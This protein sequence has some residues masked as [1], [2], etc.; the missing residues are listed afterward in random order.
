MIKN[1]L[2]QMRLIAMTLLTG[3]S[4]LA[5]V[6]AASAGAFA[7]N[8]QSTVGTGMAYAG[9]AAGGTLSDQF[10]N[11][12]TLGDVHGFQTE[13]DLTAILPYVNVNTNPTLLGGVLPVAGQRDGNVGI[14]ALVPASNYA[15]R[16]NQNIILGLGINSPFDL[17]TSYPGSSALNSNLGNAGIAGTS[18]IFSIDVNPNIAYQFNEQLTIAVGLQAQYMEARETSFLQPA[19]ILSGST[20]NL[21][22]G[23]TLGIDYKPMKGTSIGL[24]YRS[25]IDNTINGSITGL[26]AGGVPLP[27][28]QGDLKLRTP[29]IATLGISQ[30]VGDFWTVKGGVQ[31]T[32]WA[33]LGTAPLSGNAGARV[34]AVI[35]T[36]GIPFNYKDAWMFSTGAEYKFRPDTTLRAGI[37]YETSPI[38]NSN[39]SFRL[40]DADRLWLSAGASYAFSKTVSVDFGYSFLHA[41]GSTILNGATGPVINGPFSGSFNGN[42]HIVS[43]A[44][45]M[46]FD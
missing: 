33:V 11:P 30:D 40:P 26:T 6:T 27:G 29:G 7:I 19:G 32:N 12:A 13:T 3:A 39:R 38:D 14:N 22:W 25:G 8:E 45:K 37:G 34:A 4:V 23:Y 43:M 18:R 20:H 2:T 46:K 17:A 5:T 28:Q 36:A 21:G 16:V 15:Y 24:G 1:K 44:L 31:Y 42:V 35:G 10:W 41:F 9:V